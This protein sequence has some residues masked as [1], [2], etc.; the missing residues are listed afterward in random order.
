MPK[1]HATSKEPLRKRIAE[2]LFIAAGRFHPERKRL[3]REPEQI[4][5]SA[6]EAGDIMLSRGGNTIKGAL[7]A[8]LTGAPFGHVALYVGDGKFLEMERDAAKLVPA[9]S[10]FEKHKFPYFFRADLPPEKRSAVVA[11]ARAFV[12]APF[13]KKVGRI[14]RAREALDFPTKMPKVQGSMCSNIVAVSFARA[15]INLVPSTS[16]WR[17]GPAQLAKSKLLKPINLNQ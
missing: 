4:D 3:W 12:G 10:F 5:V 7:S 11:H 8:L 9:K 15:G 13:S 6:L 2:R 14:V 16:P 17:V 1:T